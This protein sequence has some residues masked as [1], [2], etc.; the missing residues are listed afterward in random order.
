MTRLELNNVLINANNIQQKYVKVLK[1]WM[2]WC[3]WMPMITVKLKTCEKKSVKKDPEMLKFVPDDFKTR[4]TFEKAVKKSLFALMH[5]SD[6][7]KP[8]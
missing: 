2:I 4:E 6:Q 8:Q 1:V 5:V 3:L 7:Y